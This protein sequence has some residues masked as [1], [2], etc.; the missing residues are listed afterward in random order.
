MQPTI[1]SETPVTMSELKEGLTKLRKADKEPNFRVKR[2]GEYLTSF[3][4]LPLKEATELV[5][6]LTKLS[7]PRLKDIHIAKIVDL[8]PTDPNDLKLYLQGYTIT[9]SNENAKKIV[10]IVK[11]YAE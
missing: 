7:I 2:T 8:L 9:I 10:D 3:N 4:V 5:D 11:E 1:V 6:K